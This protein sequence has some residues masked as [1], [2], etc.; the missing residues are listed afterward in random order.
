MF[1]RLDRT[2]E[3][4]DGSKSNDPVARINQIN[5]A[6]E[7]ALV[8]TMTA[9][10]SRRTIRSSASSSANPL[11][12]SS[13][14]LLGYCWMTHGY[15]PRRSAATMRDKMPASVFLR[16]NFHRRHL[17]CANSNKCETTTA[18]P[19]NVLNVRL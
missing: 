7:T 16:M 11:P 14:H 3:P 5:W 6:A 17:I 8:G 1:C 2:G 10:R 4:T 19:V 13:A 18:Q 15:R 12:F 9:A